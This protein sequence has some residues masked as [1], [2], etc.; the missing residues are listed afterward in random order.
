MTELHVL[1]IGSP[2]GDD[3]LG[4]TVV[5]LLQ[6][7]TRLKSY[8]PERL[9][10]DYHDRPGMYLLD[11]MREAKTLFLIDA[12]KTGAP[13][14]TLHCLKNEDIHTME[15]TLSTHGI[16]VAIRMGAAL[17]MLPNQLVFY[18]A[19]IGDI[20]FQFSISEPIIQAV[21]LLTAR[22]ETDILSHL[23]LYTPRTSK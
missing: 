21:E 12:I 2:F 16:G 10:L 22:L 23:A 9:R 15:S 11:L 20:H 14:G 1:G 8:S 7:R 17:N 18:G 6:Q 19:E 3:Q 13:I 4:F 5:R